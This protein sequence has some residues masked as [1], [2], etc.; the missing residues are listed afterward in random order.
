M[1]L[2][3]MALLKGVTLARA[4]AHFSQVNEIKYNIFNATGFHFFHLKAKLIL[5]RENMEGIVE[6][7]IINDYK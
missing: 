1:P 3:V 5:K 6:D 2:C 4:L 7:K